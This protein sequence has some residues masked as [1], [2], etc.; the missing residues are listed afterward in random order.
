MDLGEVS[1]VID[2]IM[3]R[4][5]I[6]FQAN[7]RE[8]RL[9]HSSFGLSRLFP[10]KTTSDSS[11]AANFNTKCMSCDYCRGLILL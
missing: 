6:A 11:L 10:Y 7:H 4:L 8:I 9:S 1:R 5:W 3:K 2:I